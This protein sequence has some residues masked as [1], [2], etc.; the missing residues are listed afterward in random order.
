[1]GYKPQTKLYNL[2]FNDYPGLEVFARGASLGKLLELGQTAMNPQALSNDDNLKD[3][4]FGFFIT[5]IASWNMEHPEIEPLPD[6]RVPAACER[7]GLPEGTPMPVTLESLMC[8]DMA[9]VLSLIVGW[10]SVLARV[11]AP[12][13]MNSSDGGMN[14]L[15]EQYLNQ[16][17]RLASPLKL[18]EQS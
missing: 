17:D 13:E 16:L 4:T 9:F 2:E 8:L 18:P 5:R 12:K 14:S 15:T 1:M 10:M 3:R 11:S 7:C 6:G